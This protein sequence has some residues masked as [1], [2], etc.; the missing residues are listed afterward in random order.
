[1]SETMLG[2]RVSPPKTPKD[3]FDWF[4]HTLWNQF[5]GFPGA[6]EAILAGDRERVNELTADFLD[7]KW[8]EY[9]FAFRK[10]QAKK[11]WAEVIE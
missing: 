7:V 5:I 2:G 9:A 11:R 3:Y 10:E 8:P 6:M 4:V 1:M